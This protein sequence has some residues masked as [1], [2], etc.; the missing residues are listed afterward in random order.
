MPDSGKI[1]ITQDQA[2]VSHSL[3]QAFEGQGYEAILLDPSSDPLP[4]LPDVAGLVMIQD[5]VSSPDSGR[6]TAFLKTAFALAHENGKHLQAAGAR[7]GAFLATLTFSGG[8]FGVP[9]CR[10]DTLPEYGGLAGLAKTAAKE[11]KEVLCHAWTCPATWMSAINM[12]KPL[13]R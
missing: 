13:L 7:K 5:Q 12:P 8:G 1:Y 3:K 6:A 9:P 4:D 11:W 2:Q 10:F